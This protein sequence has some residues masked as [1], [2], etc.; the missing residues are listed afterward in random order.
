MSHSLAILD[1]GNV[2]LELHFERFTSRCAEVSGRTEEEIHAKY[3]GGDAKPDFERGKMTGR[4]FFAEMMDWMHWPPERLDDLKYF[5]SDIFG[6]MPGARAAITAFKACGLVWVL[7]DTDPVHIDFIRERY[8]WSLDVDRV[9]TSYERGMSKREP[10]SFS[11]IIKEAG[12]PAERILFIDDIP[13]N[14][15]AARQAG[16]DAKLFTNWNDI[17]LIC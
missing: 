13:A 5:W 16:I 6:E 11:S 15:E 17:L 8:P 12:V 10:G 3:L 9:L 14:I 4:A 1:L 7:S 2:L